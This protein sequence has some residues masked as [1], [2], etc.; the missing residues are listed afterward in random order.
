MEHHS[1]HEAKAPNKVVALLQANAIPVSIII[2]GLLIGSAV[3][4]NNR[5]GGIRSGAGTAAPAAAD[6]TQP[7]GPVKAANIDEIKIVGNPFIGEVNAP[8]VVAYWYD[9]QCPF[10]K[11]VE[12]DV[13]PQLVSDYVN[14]GKVKIVFKGY[15]VLGQDSYSAALAERGIWATYPG[16]F[17]EWHKQ[18]FE[19]QDAENSGWGNRQDILALA[20][21]LGMDSDKLDKLIVANA[22]ANQKDLQ[23][24]LEEGQAYGV[25]G[26]P[27]FMIGKKLIVGSVPYAQIKAAVD[28]VLNGK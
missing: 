15:P 14:T 20:K 17:Y 8:V 12:G 13:F 3:V 5:T 19:K 2:A 10:C 26:T 23:A 24:D 11:K 18:M 25:T 27:S 16:Q 1:P 4:L 21:S 6:G 22:A 7:S 9:Y 28:V